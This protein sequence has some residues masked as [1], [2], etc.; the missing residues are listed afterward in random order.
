VPNLENNANVTISLKTE[1]TYPWKIDVSDYNV[2]E[3]DN[4]I[5]SGTDHSLLEDDY[6]CEIEKD[7]LCIQQISLNFISTGICDAKGMK[8]K[9]ILF[10]SRSIVFFLIQ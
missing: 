2:T 6:D 4:V 1:V 7:A 8:K 9:T 5:Q 3:H 10:F